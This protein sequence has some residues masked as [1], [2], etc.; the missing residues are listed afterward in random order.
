MFDSILNNL[1]SI[2]TRINGKIMSALDEPTEKKGRDAEKSPEFSVTEIDS[3]K[4]ADNTSTVATTTNKYMKMAEFYKKKYAS[5]FTYDPDA[6]DEEKAEKP[7]KPEKTEMPEK[8]K[9]YDRK[10]RSSDDEDESEEDAEDE[11]IN[12]KI[13]EN[14]LEL[15]GVNTTKYKE[16]Y[17]QAGVEFAQSLKNL[18][19]ELLDDL[20]DEE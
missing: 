11:E 1:D 14:D 5:K 4:R 16:E 8:E 10:R 17:R 2:I 18:T 20:F 6:K 15:K 12:M 13:D 3:K 7:E 19:L 9:K